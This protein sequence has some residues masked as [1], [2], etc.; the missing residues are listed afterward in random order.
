MEFIL[1]LFFLRKSRLVAVA[2]RTH[3]QWIHDTNL[4]R[5]I[6]AR[7][8]CLS[9]VVS[10]R[11]HYYG[12][13]ETDKEGKAITYSERL[14]SLLFLRRLNLM[15]QQTNGHLRTES[16][17]SGFIKLEKRSSLS[18][19]RKENS[20]VRAFKYYSVWRN[21]GWRAT[22][23]H[24]RLHHSNLREFSELM[25]DLTS[26]SNHQAHLKLHI[27]A[28]QVI[29]QTLETNIMLKGSPFDCVQHFW[30]VLYK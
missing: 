5:L 24:P 11:I 1:L 20:R 26:G 29:S 18:R 8:Q 14:Q 7:R 27:Y 19:R 13:C 6:S 15:G 12:V 22:L 2:L 25:G 16:R 21:A 3:D 23:S 28:S 4:H 10:L 17:K 30:D 9:A